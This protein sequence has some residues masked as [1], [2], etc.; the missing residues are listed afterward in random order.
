MGN[1]KNFSMTLII[2]LKEL[3]QLSS[4]LTKSK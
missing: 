1:M 2:Y 4:S 3:G